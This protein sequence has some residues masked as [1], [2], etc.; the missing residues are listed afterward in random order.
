MCSISVDCT[1]VNFEPET[2]TLGESYEILELIQKFEAKFKQL[3]DNY[4]SSFDTIM[5]QNGFKRILNK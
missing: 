1:R 4:V 5:T 3:V 2:H